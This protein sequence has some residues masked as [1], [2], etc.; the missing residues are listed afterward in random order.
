MQLPL[1]LQP[2]YWLQVRQELEQIKNKSILMDMLYE[3]VYDMTVCL[4]T[5]SLLS[6][7]YH[8]QCRH[9]LPPEDLASSRQ[10]QKYKGGAGI[11][12]RINANGIEQTRKLYRDYALKKLNNFSEVSSP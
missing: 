4:S 10:L 1:D 6:D 12:K 5:G 11:A 2:K 3:S 9:G 7:L 8:F